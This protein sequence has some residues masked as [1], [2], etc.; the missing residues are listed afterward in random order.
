V[1]PFIRQMVTLQF[2][3][4]SFLQMNFYN[5]LAVIVVSLFT[6]APSAEMIHGLVFG[7]ATPEQKAITCKSLNAWDIF[8]LVNVLAIT[9]A[10]YIYFW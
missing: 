9:A 7:T 10:F 5:L 3:L 2:E 8:K 4:V 6:K 1:L